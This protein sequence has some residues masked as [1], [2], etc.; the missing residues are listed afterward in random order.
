MKYFIIIAMTMISAFASYFLKRAT[1]EEKL[2][3]TFLS[4]YF[5]LGGFLY[6]TAVFF[7]IWLLQILPYAVILPIG[8][9]TYIWTMIISKKMLK[10]QITARKLVGIGFIICGV[11]CVALGSR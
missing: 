10:E 6:V 2:Y 5:Y 4:I 9:I 11:I 8:S 7:N 1:G 3:K